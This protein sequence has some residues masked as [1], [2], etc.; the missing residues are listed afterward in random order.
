MTRPLSGCRIAAAGALS[1]LVLTVAAYVFGWVG[2][3]AGGVL[4]GF[5]A[6]VAVLLIADMAAR[7]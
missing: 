1:L 5:F 6:A 2:E 3:L 7:T 4:A